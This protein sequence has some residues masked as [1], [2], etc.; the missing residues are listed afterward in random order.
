MTNPQK[1]T[2][3]KDNLYHELRCLLG[4]VTIWQMLK[5]RKAGFDVVVAEDSAFIH[6]RNLFNFFTW[7]GRYDVSVVDFGLTNPYP[8][9]LFDAWREPLNRHVLHISGGRIAPTNI[10]AGVHLKDQVENFA[11]EILSL[12]KQAENDTPPTFAALFTKARERAV[13]DAENDASG[14]ISPIFT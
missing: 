6:A 3:I 7:R 13:K 12:W 4:A 14:R 1:Q 5:Q 9:T 8:S 10:V 11:W 2:F